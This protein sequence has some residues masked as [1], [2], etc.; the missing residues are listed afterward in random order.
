MVWRWCL[1][2]DSDLK[3]LEIG[4]SAPTTNDPAWAMPAIMMAVWKG[5][6]ITL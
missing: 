1:T 5:L 3:A 6:V 2:K 4:L